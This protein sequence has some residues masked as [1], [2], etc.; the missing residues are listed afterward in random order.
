MGARKEGNQVLAASFWT[1]SAQILLV[2]H[3]GKSLL[4]LWAGAVV[5]LV[6]YTGADAVLTSIC[7]LELPSLELL[8]FS[9]YQV[10][11]LTIHP[12]GVADVLV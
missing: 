1:H 5:F 7:P 6:T 12:P 8:P 3:V 4:D 11:L 9:G 2:V 10:L